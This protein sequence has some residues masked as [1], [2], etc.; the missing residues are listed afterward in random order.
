MRRLALAGGA[1]SA[2]A[3]LLAQAWRLQRAREL[4]RNAPPPFE[5]R[6]PQ[7]RRRV[8]LAGDSTGVGV[9]CEHRAQTIA[10]QL[11]CEFD[12]V[13]LVNTCASGA[14][15]ADVLRT[16][17][18][19]PPGPGFDLALV[20]AGGNDVLCHTRE[21]AVRADAV[22]LLRELRGRSRHV[23]WAGVANVGLAPAFLPPLSWWVSRRTRRIA[24]VLADCAQAGG[25]VF[26][27][28]F[29]ERGEDPFSADAPRFYAPDGVHPSAAAYAWCYRGMRPHLLP[30]M[31]GTP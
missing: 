27:D 25:A 26:V 13:E 28:F 6:R 8:L 31:V 19:L 12:G 20:F 22:E 29:R 2:A 15:V 9:G 1:L 14:R 24:R 3:L 4:A 5:Q 11:A 30:D 23:L 21:Q 10:A 16:V 7:P 18:S 17:R